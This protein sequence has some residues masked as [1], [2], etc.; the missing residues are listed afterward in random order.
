M[1]RRALLA[2]VGT[3][4][5]GGCARPVADRLAG[6][7]PEERCQS[8][9][10]RRVTLA[11]TAPSPVAGLEF[12]AT[13]PRTRV[14][15]EA[16]ARLRLTVTNTGPTREFTYLSTPDVPGCTPFNRDYSGSA[17][18]GL[19]LHYLPNGDAGDVL[20]DRRAG[21]CWSRDRPP[22]KARG[23]ADYGCA[24]GAFPAGETRTWEYAVVDDYR[25]SPYF[26]SG[27]YRFDLA[28][29]DPAEWEWWLT[30]R[31]PDGQG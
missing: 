19:W 14:T 17:P 29:R 13:V 18:G 24:S 11:E 6:A 8:P 16:P 22:W 10:E 23:F 5:T 15:V 4:A 30:L 9:P 12:E 21:A 2:A 7:T 20:E 1:R 3:V 27:T 26:P 25:Q 28:T 31:V